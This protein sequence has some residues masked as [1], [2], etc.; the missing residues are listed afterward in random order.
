MSILEMQVNALMR[1]CLA[2]QESEQQ[3]ACM[4]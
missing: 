3:R 1:L 4:I 2:E